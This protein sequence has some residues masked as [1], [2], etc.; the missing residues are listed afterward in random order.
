M[1]DE[2]AFVRTKLSALELA[3]VDSKRTSAWLDKAI[4]AVI[5]IVGLFV[6]A[7]LGLK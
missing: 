5:A 3:G 1:E 2:V 7:K 6:A 4:L